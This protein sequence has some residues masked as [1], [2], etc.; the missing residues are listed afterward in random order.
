V[1]IVMGHTSC[2]AVYMQCGTDAG[3]MGYGIHYKNFLDEIK[4]VVVAENGR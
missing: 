4:P 3:A 1:I 2:G